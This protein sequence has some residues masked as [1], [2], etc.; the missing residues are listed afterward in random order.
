MEKI[1]QR[2]VDKMNG[3]GL[4]TRWATQWDDRLGADAGW[5]VVND[6]KG[7]GM[8]G[9]DATEDVQVALRNLRQRN[10]SKVKGKIQVILEGVLK[11]LEFE[12]IIALRKWAD[13]Q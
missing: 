10:E 2:I 5:Q 1:E 3:A 8:D 12:D 13:R 4:G 7:E 9:V 6:L 11:P